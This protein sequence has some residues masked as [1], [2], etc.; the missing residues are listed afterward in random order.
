MYTSDLCTH[1]VVA[2]Y[3]TMKNKEKVT[4]SKSLKKTSLIL[5]TSEN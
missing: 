1:Y 2:V 3:R 5:R 4:Y